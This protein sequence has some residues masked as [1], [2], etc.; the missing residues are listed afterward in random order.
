MKGD[1]WGFLPGAGVEGVTSIRATMFLMISG[2]AVVLDVRRPTS[3]RPSSR[4][5]ARKVVKAPRTRRGRRRVAERPAPQEGGSVEAWSGLDQN[6]VWPL[7][8]PGPT[9]RRYDHRPGLDPL[10]PLSKSRVCGKHMRSRR[11]PGGPAAVA[12]PGPR[13]RTSAG[14][15]YAR[16]GGTIARNN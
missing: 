1:Q 13:L 12:T 10:V 7:G 3:Q 11:S 4:P 16:L 14:R 6:S 8:K 15:L 2:P 9:A 5:A